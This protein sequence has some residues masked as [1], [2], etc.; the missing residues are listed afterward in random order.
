M[1]T[2]PEVQKKAQEEIDDVI[3]GLPTYDDAE[4]LP[5]VQAMIKEIHR[6]YVV[7]P[8]NAPHAT[9]GDIEVS[10]FVCQLRFVADKSSTRGIFYQRDPSSWGTCVGL[11]RVKDCQEHLNLC[12]DAIY[13]D[14]GKSAFTAESTTT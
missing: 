3:G 10:Y 1:V 9:T 12:A 13:H 7:A 14:E 4:N 8:L 6:H 5:Y 11:T 2:H